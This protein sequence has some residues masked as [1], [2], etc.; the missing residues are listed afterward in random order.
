MKYGKE[1]TDWKKYDTEQNE[2]R[3]MLEDIC[4][5]IK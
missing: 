1:V 3:E 2:K 4:N 5:E